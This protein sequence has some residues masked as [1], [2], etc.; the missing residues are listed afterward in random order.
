MFCVQRITEQ[1]CKT[2]LKSNNYSQWHIYKLLIYMMPGTVLSTGTG[3]Q[4]Y[5]RLVSS[6]RRLVIRYAQKSLLGRRW[7]GV[8]GGGEG[9]TRYDQN[10]KWDMNICSSPQ[11]YIHVGITLGE[12]YC[13]LNIH[14]CCTKYNKQHFK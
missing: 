5:T 7:G 10:T 13:V 12:K 6:Q 14:K 1:V 2:S 4:L 3:G 11:S 8:R 9:M